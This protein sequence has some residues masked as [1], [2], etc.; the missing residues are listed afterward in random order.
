MSSRTEPRPPLPPEW[1][2]VVQLSDQDVAHGHFEGRVEH[3]VSGQG[4]RFQSL[5]AL[6]AFLSH[7]LAN[8]HPNRNRRP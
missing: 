4:T 7:I 6:V 3:V 8:Q 1:A 5:D 2:F